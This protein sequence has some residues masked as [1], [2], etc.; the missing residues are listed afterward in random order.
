[1]YSAFKYFEKVFDTVCRDVIFFEMLLNNIDAKM[2]KVILN[3]YKH[4]K[5][6]ISYNNCTT[7]YFACENGVR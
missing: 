7:N 2:H 3:M 6:C 1:L 5:L 4:I